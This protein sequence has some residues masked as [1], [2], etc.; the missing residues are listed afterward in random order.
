MHVNWSLIRNALEK[1]MGECLGL[2]SQRTTNSPHSIATIKKVVRTQIQPHQI[3][4]NE[5][6]YFQSNNS[7]WASVPPCTRSKGTHREKT[8]GC[9]RKKEINES[10]APK[11]L[12]YK[13]RKENWTWKIVWIHSKNSI[14]PRCFFFFF[15]NRVLLLICSRTQYTY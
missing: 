11:W 15:L 14:D 12:K 8:L 9:R 1:M 10:R 2:F 4:I 5:L 7:H 6:S 13:M 3:S